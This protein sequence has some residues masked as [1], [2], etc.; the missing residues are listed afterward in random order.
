MSILFG[1]QYQ[2]APVRSEETEAGKEEPN[3]IC[4]NEEVTV[5]GN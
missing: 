2:E 5:V 4:L 3:D 1:R